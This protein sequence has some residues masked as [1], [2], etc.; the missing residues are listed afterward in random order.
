MG[1]RNNAGFF[2]RLKHFYPEIGLAAEILGVLI[3]LICC[4]EF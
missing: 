3:M 1:I 2:E 4:V